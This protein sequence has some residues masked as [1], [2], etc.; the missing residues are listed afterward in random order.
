MLIQRG[1]N[2]IK[3]IEKVVKTNSNYSSCSVSLNNEDISTT[4]SE[5]ST[6]ILINQK[7]RS[8]TAYPKIQQYVSNLPSTK[9]T[10]SYN[11]SS[12]N[13]SKISKSENNELKIKQEIIKLAENYDFK[14]LCVVFNAWSESNLDAMIGTLGRSQI[15]Y[16]LNLII[17]NYKKNLIANYKISP[18]LKSLNR[19]KL[20][21][22]IDKNLPIT[23]KEVRDNIRKIYNR[24][25]FNDDSHLYDKSKKFK[26]VQ[27]LLISDYENLIE[28]ELNNF[29]PDLASFWLKKFQKQ[30]NQDQ[31]TSKL[32]ELIMKLENLG[33]FRIWDIYPNR[34]LSDLRIN[35]KFCYYRNN[36]TFLDINCI[37]NKSDL[38]LDFH[39]SVVYYFGYTK[40]LKNLFSYLEI[41][42][43]I[44][45]QGER[46]GTIL[47]STHK[48]FPD[49]KF[50]IALFQSLI[51]NLEFYQTI[52]FIN[53]FQNLYNINPTMYEKCKIYEMIFKWANLKTHF[54]ESKALKYY[55]KEIGMD[56]SIS[57]NSLKDAQ[58][59]INFD[60]EGY[61]QFI[62][63][64]KQERIETFKQCWNLIKNDDEFPFSSLI[65]KTYIDYYLKEQEV[66]NIN[67][68]DYYEIMRNLQLKYE[69]YFIDSQSFTSNSSIR[70]DKQIITIYTEILKDFI[71]IK[72][73]QFKFGQIIPLINEWSL[74]D[75]MIMELK[76][77]IQK[78]NL[79][80]T[81]KLQLEQKRTEFI[82]S[83]QKY[84]N[85][86]YDD[87]DKN[88]EKLLNLI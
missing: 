62:E 30:Y 69:K 2:G 4:I 81:Y 52:N 39:I 48:L 7:T 64:L 1:N 27:N 50:L 43:G 74:D 70:I 58:N 79:I 5:A 6:N 75:E 45:S 49:V 23:H 38:S 47:D 57:P 63:K 8:T 13:C 82:N 35:N 56:Q 3:L 42:L 10:E 46:T 21:K 84:D 33:D 17:S 68:S 59:N 9:L 72:F 61:L 20:Q 65:Y 12:I 25:I 76:S 77:W 37:P 11:I 19:V 88:D 29:K 80:R 78:E 86:D 31:I 87:N 40:Q 44:N 53:K 71:E 28:F 34:E 14:N 36:K 55:C 26:E 32:W 18:V 51:L 83:L 60:Y 54:I 67:E 22:S 85:D 73:K 16:Y 15:S 66:E 41:I 24:L